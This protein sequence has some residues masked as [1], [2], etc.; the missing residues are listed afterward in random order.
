M[1][2]FF[3]LPQDESGSR[4][5]LPL[6]QFGLAGIKVTARN[7]AF[8]YPEAAP[9]FERFNLDVAPGEKVVVLCPSNMQKTV[10]AKVLVGL[11]PPSAGVVRYNGMN[12]VEV[13]LESIDACRSLMLDSHPTLLEGTIEDNITLGR[14]SITY[15]DVQWALQFVELDEEVDRMPEGLTTNVTGHANQFTLSQIF[16][17]LLARAIVTRPHVLIVDGTLHSMAPSVREVILRRLCSKD[18]PWSIIFISNNPTFR[19]YVDRRVTL[20]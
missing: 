20:E 10:L 12:L 5:V 3:S 4:T 13:S 6:D 19:S 11:L 2:A 1:N 16:R 18:E 9:L 17:L 8:A 15:E 7:L 14:G